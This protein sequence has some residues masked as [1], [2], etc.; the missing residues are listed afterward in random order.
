MKELHTNHSEM[1]VFGLI[2]IVLGLISAFVFIAY[3]ANISVPGFLEFSEQRFSLLL[4]AL[5]YLLS[6]WGVLTRKKYMWSATI[7]F[8]AVSIIGNIAGFFFKGEFF[9]VMIVLSA[10][11]G[12]YLFST[13]AKEWY[14]VQ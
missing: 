1:A 9:I 2:Y 13:P 8:M 11:C 12:L 10:I 5:V 14:G 7:T 6:A 4:L 3:T